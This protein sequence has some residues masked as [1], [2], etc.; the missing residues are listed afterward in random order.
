MYRI[1]SSY[2]LYDLESEKDLMREWLKKL[3]TEKGLTQKEIGE[4]LGIS[5]S[6][7]SSI[8]NGIRQ[9]KM[10]MVIITGISAALDIPVIEVI[11]EEDKLRTNV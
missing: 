7:Y 8:E 9:K 1:V 11:K 6:Y 5:E 3:R 10:D 4:K 2:K